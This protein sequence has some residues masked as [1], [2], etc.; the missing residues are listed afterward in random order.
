MD[1][2]AYMVS[3]MDWLTLV[4]KCGLAGHLESGAVQH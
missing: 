2:A 4:E 3:P 1:A